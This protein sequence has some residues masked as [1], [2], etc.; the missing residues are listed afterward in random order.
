[1]E[2]FFEGKPKS[3]NQNKAGLNIKLRPNKTSFTYGFLGQKE[4]NQITSAEIRLA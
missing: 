4:I 3:T 1:M 2:S